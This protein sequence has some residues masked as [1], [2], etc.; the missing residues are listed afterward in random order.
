M[1]R[2]ILLIITCSFLSSCEYF[3]LMSHKEW[4]EKSGNDKAAVYACGNID[5]SGGYWK[6]D[7]KPVFLEDYLSST[8]IYVYE[9]DVYVAGSDSSNYPCYWKNGKKVPLKTAG[10]GASYAISV[11]GGTVFNA[12][13]DTSQAYL[14]INEER[15]DL[16]TDGALHSAAFSIFV[17]E[18]GGGKYNIIIGGSYYTSTYYACYW[19]DGGSKFVPLDNSGVTS[20]VSSV[21]YYK[22]KV[23]SVGYNGTGDSSYR[24]DN[25]VKFT[26]SNALFNSIYVSEDNVYITG[27]ENTDA[28]LIKNS[29]PPIVLSSSSAVGLS[30]KVFND[31]I[32]TAGNNMISSNNHACYWIN[33]SSQP[34]YFNDEGAANSSAASIFITWDTH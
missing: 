2:F 6:N 28:L 30:V 5:T 27:N 25:A 20:Q 18:S 23:Y 1:K 13:I 14:W 15:F 26:Y 10:T 4:R 34:V 17:E 21:F 31:T 12:G 8:S 16:R 33:T 19:T 22:G 29:L 3:T 9:G 24:V 7:E 32:Y 11:N